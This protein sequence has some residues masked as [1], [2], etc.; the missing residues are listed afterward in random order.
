LVSGG[1][2][3]GPYRSVALVVEDDPIQRDLIALLLEESD[4]ERWERR[5]FT[6]EPRSIY[7]LRG[8]ARTLWEHSIPSVGSLRY[9]IT[10]RN[11]R[12]RDA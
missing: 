4:F 5:S 7:L 9:S 3:A 6:A 12:E 2:H 11:V 10:F 1:S 8:A